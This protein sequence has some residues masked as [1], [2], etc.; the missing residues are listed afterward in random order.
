MYALNV[1]EVPLSAI[2]PIWDQ[3]E[4]MAEADALAVAEVEEM[5]EGIVEEGLVVDVAVDV[6]PDDAL[7]EVDVTFE[8]E[9]DVAGEVAT[10]DSVEVEVG[11]SSL[12]AFS[13]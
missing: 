11:V 6:F 8:I 4:G 1:L 9:P 10:T 5:E 3:P 7:I 2:Q 13:L 12:Y